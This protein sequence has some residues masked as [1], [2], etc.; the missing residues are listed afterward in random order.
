MAA[1]VIK[2]DQTANPS[3]LGI[4]GKARID[5]LRGSAVT[6]R[7][8][9]NSGVTRWSWTLLD[10][11]YNSAANIINPATAVA[12]ITPDQH[13]PY[14]VR[15]VVNDGLPTV[16]DGQVYE[17]CFYVLDPAGIS[18]PAAGEKAPQNN[19]A[20]S[21]GIYNQ[22]GFARMMAER[23]LRSLDNRDD[24]Q[25][26]AVTGFGG[27]IVEI[28]WGLPAAIL[29]SIEIVSSTSTNSTFR[30]TADAAGLFPIAT[31]ATAVDATLG[32]S[33]YEPLFCSGPLGVGLED[34][35]I[36][37]AIENNDLSDSNYSIYY[38]LKAP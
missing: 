15:L 21:P 37:L 28:R 35:Q 29:Q 9:D 31:L 24:P 8:A 25:V 17:L 11:P 36:Y 20:I 14:R 34:G 30:L 27:E 5:I 12:T 4:P 3:P 7:N 22:Q 13:G 10:R 23:A 19:Y 38:R 16:D 18:I 1:A 32:W 2:I 26:V 33:R 6:L